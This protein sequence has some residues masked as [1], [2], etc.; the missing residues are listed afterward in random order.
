MVVKRSNRRGDC[1][2]GVSRK[3]NKSRATINIKNLKNK[4][5]STHGQISF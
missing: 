1:P 5:N 2:I 4:Y 3:G